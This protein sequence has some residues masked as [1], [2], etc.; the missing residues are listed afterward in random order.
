MKQR[1]SRLARGNVVEAVK[2]ATY[3]KIYIYI[4]VANL[5]PKLARHC[6]KQHIL[7]A[8]PSAWQ[9]R[10]THPQSGKGFNNPFLPSIQDV[11]EM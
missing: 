4:E 10:A 1:M 3:R 11:Q 2:E 6:C 9:P 7:L 8:L 5:V